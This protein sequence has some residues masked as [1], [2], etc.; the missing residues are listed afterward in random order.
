M[1]ISESTV[2]RN[3]KDVP[4]DFEYHSFGSFYSFQY[5]ALSVNLKFQRYGSSIIQNF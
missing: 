4:C 5:T 2:R 3:H 1:G